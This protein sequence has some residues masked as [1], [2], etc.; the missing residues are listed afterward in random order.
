[1]N[2]HGVVLLVVVLGCF[3]AVVLGGSRWAGDPG[4][5]MAPTPLPSRRGRARAPR[6]RVRRRGRQDLPKWTAVA[7]GAT[8][9][10]V[11]MIVEPLTVVIVV[12]LAWVVMWRL[13]LGH[14]RAR[15][16]QVERAM[17][18]L[19]DLVGVAVATGQSVAFVI[20]SVAQRAPL[21]L[22]GMTQRANQRIRNGLPVVQTLELLAKELGT[23]G[24]AMCGALMDAHQNGARAGPALARLAEVARSQRRQAAEARARRLPVALLFP[25]VCCVLPAFGLLAVV[26]LLAASLK[27]VG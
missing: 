8:S 18:D 16:R 14:R 5:D 26:P 2:W 13:R 9:M 4:I 15:E 27:A 12:A 20:A 19:I 17:P 21:E 3:S 24:R 10:L 7:S 11:A 6:P 25:L 22:R 23:P 1:M